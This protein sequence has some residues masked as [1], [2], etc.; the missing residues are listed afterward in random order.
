MTAFLNEIIEKNRRRVVDD[1][2]SSSAAS[3]G[4]TKIMRRKAKQK[5]TDEIQA[6][7]AASGGMNFIHLI[8]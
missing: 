4:A 7:T 3:K 1:L 8:I 5:P 2:K 6:K